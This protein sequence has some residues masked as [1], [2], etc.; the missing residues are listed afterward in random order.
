MPFTPWKDI[1]TFRQARQL[2]SG[3]GKLLRINRDVLEARRAQDLT[4]T[5]RAL[6]QATKLKD[7]RAVAALR[8]KLENQL[9]K[10]FPRTETSWVRENVDVLLVAVIVAM[11]VRTFF[12]QPFQIPT[13]SMQPTLFG[14]HDEPDTGRHTF[15][16]VQLLRFITVGKWC[17][18]DSCHVRGDHIFVDKISYH[19]RKPNRGEV[20]V[21][22][23]DDIAGLQGRASGKFYIKRLIAVEHDTVQIDPP[24]V[25]INGHILDERPAFRRIYSRLGGYHGYTIPPGAD[26]I[27]DADTKYRIPDG[28]LFVMGDNSPNSLDG[29]YWGSFPRHSLVGR[30]IL[31]YWPYSKRLGPID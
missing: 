25:L 24:H 15:L 27:R 3:T 22:A 31:V 23:T 28:C 9:E 13:G 8:E 26:I 20:I 7:V 18:E 11:A 21:F 17:R 1:R 19:F 12:I 14:I 30:A 6:Q 16:P 29:R 10:A 4:S 5:S 2:A